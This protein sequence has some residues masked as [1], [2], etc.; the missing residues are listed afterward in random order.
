M[1]L[2]VWLLELWVALLVTAINYGNYSNYTER[3]RRSLSSQLSNARSKLGNEQNA[4]NDALKRNDISVTNLSFK[5]FDD[6]LGSLIQKLDPEKTEA[7]LSDLQK[8]I[9]EDKAA[10]QAIDEVIQKINQL[11]LTDLTNK[12]V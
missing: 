1:L 7:E 12:K 2:L 6:D 9:D 11:R 4:L 8:K 3:Q 5:N 10:L